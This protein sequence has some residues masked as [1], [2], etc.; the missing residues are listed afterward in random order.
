MHSPYNTPP[1]LGNSDGPYHLVQY[2]KV[3][4][5]V[6]P[7]YPVVPNSYTLLSQIPSSTFDFTGL[8]LKDT[9]FIIPLYPDSHDLFVFTREDT[10][11]ASQGT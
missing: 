3:I 1:Y 9:F 4:V 10:P 8:E 2:L 11:T 5:T 7:M 6:L